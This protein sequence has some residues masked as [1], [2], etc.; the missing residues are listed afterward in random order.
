M[1]LDTV[2]AFRTTETIHRLIELVAKKKGQTK[3]EFIATN[4]LDHAMQFE[5]VRHMDTLADFLD[6][7]LP[8]ITEGLDKKSADEWIKKLTQLQQSY[9]EQRLDAHIRTQRHLT[10]IAIRSYLQDYAEEMEGTDGFIINQSLQVIY[11]ELRN[12]DLISAEEF[13]EKTSA[14]DLYMREVGLKLLLEKDGS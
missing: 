8:Y 3:S 14:Y 4:S 12:W 1:I 11:E 7:A 9:I 2:V 13:E 5:K 10:D 6:I